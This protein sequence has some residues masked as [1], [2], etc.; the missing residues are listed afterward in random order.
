MNKDLIALIDFTK[1]LSIL[2]VEDNNEV[3][4]QLLKFLKNFFSNIDVAHDGWEALE[5][6]EK[7]IDKYDLIITDISMPRIDG[8][9]F[10][11]KVKEIKPKQNILIISAHTENNK[12][13]ILKEIQVFD[14]LQKPVGYQKLVEVLTKLKNSYN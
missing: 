13:K 2:F 9:E 8:I 5:I 1:S 14:I 7:N 4:N 10:S 3:R 6:Y 12:L 11:K